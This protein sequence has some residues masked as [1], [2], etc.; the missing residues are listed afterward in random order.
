MFSWNKYE[1]P[2]ATRRKTAQDYEAKRAQEVFTGRRGALRSPTGGPVSLVL[3]TRIS[4][5]ACP[6]CAGR[7]HKTR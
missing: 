6:H 5:C 1:A 2:G 7:C 3:I 4:C